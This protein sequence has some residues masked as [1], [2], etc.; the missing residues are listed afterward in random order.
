MLPAKR[1][2]WECKPRIAALRVL[3]GLRS[4][5]RL[6]A[7]VS[8]SAT[9]E[10]ARIAALRVLSGLRSGTRLVAPVSVSATGERAR[11]AALR[12]LS[13]LRSGTRLVAPVSV[14]ATGERARIA[15]LRA[16]SGLPIP[17]PRPGYRLPPICNTAATLRAVIRTLAAAFASASSRV[18]TE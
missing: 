8:V 10:R 12:V 6:V 11:I 1:A 13:G 16:L 9:G 2:G 14:S 5:T 17:L 15:A 7:P 18:Q 4:G 3:S